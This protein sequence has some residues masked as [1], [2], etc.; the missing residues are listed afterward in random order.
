MNTIKSLLQINKKETI[1][2]LVHFIT[3][4]TKREFKKNGGVI[5]ISGGVDSALCSLLAVQ[6]LGN[7]HVFA[8]LLPEKESDPK[9]LQ[10]GK[11]FCNK[12]EIKYEIINITKILDKIGVYRKKDNL[13]NEVFPNYEPKKHQTSLKFPH[14]LLSEQKIVFPIIEFYEKDKLIYSK[15]LSA[16]QYNQIVSLQN[17]KQRIRMVLLYQAAE[18][19]N[20]IVLGTTNKTENILGQ[21]VKY[22]DGGVDIEPL[23]DLYK[24]QVYKLA[25]YLDIPKEIINRPASPDTWSKFTSDEDFYWRMPLEILDRILVSREKKIAIKEIANNLEMKEHI[26]S[27]CIDIFDSISSTTK[28]FFLTP[29]TPKTFN[30]DKK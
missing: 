5:G 15:R 10:F 30:E 4:Q 21:F 11:S 26:I 8:L 28:H 24:T 17:I 20:F 13:L 29:P 14:D 18:S 6:A 25:K 2:E 16:N 22:G 7:E 3:V 1:Q 19:R 27:R 23:A 12:L 9:S